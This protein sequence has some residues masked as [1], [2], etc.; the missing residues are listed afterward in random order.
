M[1][2][3]LSWQSQ[4]ALVLDEGTGIPV[5]YDVIPGNAVDVS[6]LAQTRADVE[7]TLGVTVSSAVL[8]AGYVTK[9]LV[10]GEMRYLARMPARRGFPFKTMW[11]RV[12]CT[13]AVLQVR[14][15]VA[16]AGKGWSPTDLWGKTSS[17]MCF[18]SGPS[19][20][21]E[22]PSRQCRERFEGLGLKVPAKVDV[23][24]YRRDVLG[25]KS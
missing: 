17:L 2:T 11:H 12:A 18:R 10:C 22:T 7:A 1:T 24:A 19:L 9:A 4:L 21:L 15:A 25:L 13:V 23:A 20:V 14:K 16:A 5:W 8:D 6:A 3:G